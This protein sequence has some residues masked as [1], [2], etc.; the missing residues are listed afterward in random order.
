MAKKIDLFDLLLKNGKVTQVQL[1]SAIN[2]SKRTGLSAVDSLQKLGFVSEE[3]IAKAQAATLGVPFVS[4]DDYSSDESA[5]ELIPEKLAFKYNV[6]PLFKIGSS[7]TIAMADPADVV[8][9]D[10]IRN[11]CK[12]DIVEPVLAT[13]K[14]ILKALDFYYGTKE[15]VDAVAKAIEEDSG[16]DFEIEVDEDK[17]QKKELLEAAEEV[18]IIK[19]VNMLIKKAV[20]EGASDVH[21]EPEVS[22][23][24]VRYRVDGT[25]HE[26]NVFSKKLQLAIIS[27]IKILSRIDIT[28]NRRPQDGRIRLKLEGKN[29]DI[30]VSTF[31]TIHGENVVMRV[32]D[33]SATL[34]GLKELGLNEDVRK[35]FEH[36]IHRPTGI[37]LVTGP[38]GS[39]KTT[40][41]YTVLNALRSVAKNII[42]LEDP[43]EYELPLVRQ[44]QI[45][46]KAGLTFANGLRSIL[47]QDPEIVMVGEIRD[48]ETVDIAIQASLTGQLV[49]STLHTNDAA[50]SLTRLID[51]GVEPF[52]IASSVIGIMAQRLVRKICSLCKEKYIPTK[53]VLDGLGIKNF[54]ELYRGKG[55]KHCKGTGYSG[56]IGIYELLVINE[57]IRQLINTKRS[58]DEI[59]RVAVKPTLGN[60]ANRM[61][62]MYED[63]LDKVKNGI[64]TIDEVLRVTRLEGGSA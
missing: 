7:L 10:H 38:T 24:K 30:R 32:L 49:F 13:Q 31:P 62:T 56:R 6:I 17:L 26:A 36:L 42:T 43:V 15:S 27:R 34:L 41:L 16:G 63:G 60:Y 1:D 33:K 25:L 61:H 8:A 2:D 55:C 52:L 4:L 5:I 37:V 57:E 50:H 19:L 28:E 44:S 29:I 35:T 3:E 47:R 64:T 11:L 58:A 54:S 12:V 40:T 21:I 59:M 46:V 51:M 45:N 39:G 14:A 18:P 23:L 53:D 22:S 48:K 9:I 20:S